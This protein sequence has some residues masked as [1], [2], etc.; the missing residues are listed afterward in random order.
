MT[1]PIP[2]RRKVGNY[3]PSGKNDLRQKTEFGVTPL[4][5]AKGEA[6]FVG[7]GKEAFGW[8]RGKGQLHR[9]RGNRKWHTG[10]GAEREGREKK[11]TKPALRGRGDVE[12]TLE[13]RVTWGGRNLSEKFWE[14]SRVLKVKR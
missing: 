3:C 2:S 7:K 4:Q 10:G 14:R 1:R 5:K 8:E 11:T 13:N 12:V 9:E 6:R